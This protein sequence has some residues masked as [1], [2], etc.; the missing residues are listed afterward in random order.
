MAFL[1]WKKKNKDYTT[2]IKV[3][4]LRTGHIVRLA[5]CF[6]VNTLWPSVALSP[7]PIWHLYLCRTQGTLEICNNGSCTCAFS[8]KEKF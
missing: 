6:F 7:S 1:N 5:V 8:F 2:F 4:L 3:L